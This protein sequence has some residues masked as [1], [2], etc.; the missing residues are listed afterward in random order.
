MKQGYECDKWK[1]DNRTLAG[2][3]EGLQL[4]FHSFAPDIFGKYAVKLHL[5]SGEWLRAIGDG[6]DEVKGDGR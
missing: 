1:A 5:K 4:I 2:L 3:P 6:R